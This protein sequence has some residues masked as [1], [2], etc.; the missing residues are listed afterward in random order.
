MYCW[1]QR[2]GLKHI[3]R[4]LE[5]R[6][7]SDLPEDAEIE[8]PEEAESWR[9]ILHHVLIHEISPDA[10]ERLAK[11]ILRKSGFVQVEVT[12][13]S[14]D[15]GID[16][17]GIMRLSGLLSFHVIFQCKKYKGAV[18]ASD[19]RDFRGAMIVELI[20]S[21]FPRRSSAYGSINPPL[22]RQA[23]PQRA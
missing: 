10:F 23:P 22:I 15:G 18:T 3:P 11:R 2:K 13:R 16:N 8:I 19:I 7:L 1:R 4:E 17:K 21:I 12:G 6:K 9:S 20:N 14:G 5:R